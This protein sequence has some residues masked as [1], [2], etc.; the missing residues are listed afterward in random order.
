MLFTLKAINDLERPES[1]TVTIQLYND[2]GT[3]VWSQEQEV[4]INP[5]MEK[6]Y[7]VVLDLPDEPGGYTL[8][9]RFRGTFNGQEDQ[10]SRRYLDVGRKNNR[11]FEITP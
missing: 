10:I 4:T 2:A 5:Y 7:P 3:E 11:Y 6:N 8:I 1:G 9:T